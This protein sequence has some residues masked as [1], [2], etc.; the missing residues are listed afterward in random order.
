MLNALRKSATTW[1]AKVL[2]GLLVLSFAIWGVNDFIGGINRTTVATVGDT[3]V[4]AQRFDRALSIEMSRLQRQIQQPVS[5]SQAVAFGIPNQVMS[6]LVSEAALDDVS[7]KLNLGVS[8]D[9]LRGDIVNNPSFRGPD[10]QFDRTFLQ[11]ILQSNNMTE[12]EFISDQRSFSERRQIAQGVSGGVGVPETLLKALHAYRA[13]TRTIRTIALDASDLPSLPEPGES[14]LESYF[15]ANTAT[16][17]APEYRSVSLI[18]LTLDDLIDADAVSDGDA[19]RIYEEQEERFSQEEKRRVQQLVFPNKEEAEAASAK[20]AGGTSW[21][22]LLAERNV[23]A[24]DIDLGLVAKEDMIDQTIADA[25]FD[26]NESDV[27]SV[28]EGR[29]GPVVVFVAEIQPASTRPFEEVA[30]DIKGEIARDE[31]IDQIFS[32]RDAI[33]DGLAGGASISE[34][35]ATNDLTVRAIDAVDRNG[36]DTSSTII[37]DL[38][39]SSDLLAGVYEGEVGLENP[40]LEG[41]NEFVW[42]EISGVIPERDRTID[43]VTDRILA[44]WTRDE[45]AKALDELA[46]RIAGNLTSTVS[47]DALAQA[48]VKPVNTL[49]NITRVSPTEGITAENVTSI[50][51]TQLNKFASLT[52]ADPSQRLIYQLTDSTVP[53][54]F[55]EEQTTQQI[56]QSAAPAIENEL[57]QQYIAELQETLGVSL[58]QPL[59]TQM[60]SNEGQANHQYQ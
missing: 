58:N 19:R 56:A 45:T 8:D 27:S 29:F 2:I 39:L 25:V 20:L 43:E 6:G 53:A 37:D 18:H 17:R 42:Y 60:L 32:V 23:A 38:P 48:R 33:E 26:L 54:Y 1:V 34:V 21:E 13:E 12:S 7:T 41:D 36:L 4:S 46:S 14:D 44:D 35:A 40:P 31:A 51:E 22:N 9:K 52:P 28:I 47:F 5:L 16:Y 11:Q 10:G 24:S 30:K 57:L 49:D 59:L 15:E 55:A 3:D 50:F